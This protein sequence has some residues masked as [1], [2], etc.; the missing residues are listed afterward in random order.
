MK[1]S[2]ED[3][4]LFFT[5]NKEGR[6]TLTIEY[7]NERLDEINE[8]FASGRP[9]KVDFVGIVTRQSRDGWRIANI[10][11][12]VS[13]QT[14]LPD[15]PINLD[16]AV[17]VFGTT[18]GNGVVLADRIELLPIGAPLPE[19]QGEQLEIKTEQLSATPQPNNGNSGTGSVTEMPET[20]ATTTPVPSPTPMIEIITIS[21]DN[22]NVNSNNNNDGSIISNDNGNENSGSNSNDNNNTGTDDHGGNGNGDNDSSDGNTN[23]NGG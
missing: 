19:V 18:N 13:E 16:A 10:L 5:F 11:V 23:G 4:T 21:P 17:W 8:L 12:I 2:W 14:K 9:A 1:R 6:E 20:D 22:D 15:Q 7:E 3:V